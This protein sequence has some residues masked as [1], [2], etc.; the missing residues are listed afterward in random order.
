MI[1]SE[2]YAP[3]DPDVQEKSDLQGGS[4]GS[5]GSD[6]TPT[7]TETPTET[8]T[9]T[10][11]DTPEPTPTPTD[12]P[13]PTPTSTPVPESFTYDETHEVPGP[14]YYQ[15]P[16]ESVNQFTLNWT[17]TNELTD[18]R[19]FDVFLMS[20]SEFNQ[21]IDYIDDESDHKPEVFPGGSAEGVTHDATRTATL[22]P[23]EYNLV[24]DNTDLGDAGDWGEEDPREVRIEIYGEDN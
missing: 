18:E 2:D 24:V 7:P 10:P 4:G 8:P 12:T 9:D 14:G 15:V 16:F 13:E 22:D 5:D 1:D 6:D 3:N 17:V 11:T 19:D 23:G 21:Y 20:R